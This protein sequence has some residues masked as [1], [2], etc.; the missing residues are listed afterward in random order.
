MSD[1]V[2]C[3][4]PLAV[5]GWQNVWDQN[6]GRPLMKLDDCDRL[7]AAALNGSPDDARTAFTE[8]L[9]VYEV[10]SA[11]IVRG[12]VFWRSQIADDETGFGNESR[13]TYPPPELAKVGRLN[14][15][16]APALYLSSRRETTFA[17]VNAASGHLVQLCGFRVLPGKSIRAVLIGELNHAH[18]TGYLRMLGTDPGGAVSKMLNAMPYEDARRYIYIDAFFGSVLADPLAERN[19]YWRSRMLGEMLLGKSGAGAIAFPSVKDPLGTNLAILPDVVDECMHGVTTQ[20]LRIEG[21]R[22]FNFYDRTS[23]MEATGV[24]A[25]GCYQWREPPSQ[26]DQMFY[27]FTKEESE[28]THENPRTLLDLPTHGRLTP[29]VGRAPIFSRLFPWWR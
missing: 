22:S 11:E 6:L 7:F 27:H 12:S 15:K 14:N 3:D 19:D 13:M 2:S 25:K 29:T 5:S 28:A 20:I 23:L 21:V 16:G 8:L 4:I 24:D 1:V 10:I 9:A 18:C 17:E 26:R